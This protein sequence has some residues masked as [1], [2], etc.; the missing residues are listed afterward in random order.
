MTTPDKFTLTAA[1]DA[2]GNQTRVIL[3]E[4]ETPDVSSTEI[5]RR[6][7]AGLSIDGL[8]PDA[9]ASYISRHHLYAEPAR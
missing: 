9:V 7:R 1:R 6:A 4:S 2:D 5:R 8:V 3:I